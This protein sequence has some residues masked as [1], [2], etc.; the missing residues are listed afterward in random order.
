MTEEQKETYS[1]FASEISE[2][3]GL[4][5]PVDVLKLCIVT[6]RFLRPVQNHIKRLQEENE[7]YEHTIHQNN[8]TIGK[9]QA[10]NAKLKRQNKGFIHLLEGV[11]SI[12][13]N[14]FNKLADK[15]IFLYWI[16]ENPIRVFKEERQKDFS[17][18]C[19]LSDF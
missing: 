6:D 1:A 12:F 15:E 17:F 18:D 14:G 11:E 4:E 10:E 7:Q 8:D 19:I 3:L 9:L 5:K 13:R 16:Q 2:I